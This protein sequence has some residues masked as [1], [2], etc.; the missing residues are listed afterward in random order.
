MT[1]SHTQI[2]QYL[3]CPRIYR[4]L[5]GWQ[6]KETKAALLFGRWFEKALVAYFPVGLAA[7]AAWYAFL[8]LHLAAA[9]GD[10][11][12]WSAGK[13]ALM[14]Q[15]DV[16]TV[17]LLAPNLLRSFC[18]N[19]VSSN[20]HYFGDMEDGNIIQQT[21]VATTSTAVDNDTVYAAVWAVMENLNDFWSVHP[22]AKFLELKTALDKAKRDLDFT[23]VVAPFDGVVGNK[24]V[25]LGQ[26]V[27]PGTRLLALVPLDT[28]YVEANFK[29]TQLAR[30]KPGQPVEVTFDAL[31]SRR[32]EGRV[33]S[34]APASGAQFSLLPPENATG[35]FTKIVQRVSVKIVLRPT[36]EIR[37]RS[38]E[39][40]S[41]LQ[42]H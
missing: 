16:V 31:G 2:S 23:R 17:V 4:Y 8:G 1:F 41:E 28:V 10:T 39:H 26:Y 5:D 25:Q 37:E 34:V 30:L 42:S 40:T 35:N 11:A 18:I 20:M 15:L 19:F 24:A 12:T 21:Q 32:F 29:E 6:E 33:A 3:R 22:G 13:L 14:H 38:E 27:A 36:P 7:W 9:L